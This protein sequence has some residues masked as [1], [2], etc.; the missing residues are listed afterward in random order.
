MKDLMNTSSYYFDLPQELI[1]QTPAIPRDS[2]KMLCV[3]KNKIGDYQDK[4]NRL[5]TLW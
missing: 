5:P 2:C 3:N 4:V 1:A